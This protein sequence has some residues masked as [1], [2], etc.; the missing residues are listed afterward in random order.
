MHVCTPH[1]RCG[2]GYSK[3]LLPSASL[4]VMRHLLGRVL[5]DEG[6]VHHVSVCTYRPRAC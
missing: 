5:S 3:A 4:H 2:L 6:S 1:A